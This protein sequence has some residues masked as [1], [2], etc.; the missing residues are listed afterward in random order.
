MS[1]ADLRMVL[2]FNLKTFPLSKGVKTMMMI[3]TETAV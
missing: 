2:L 1:A 3:P